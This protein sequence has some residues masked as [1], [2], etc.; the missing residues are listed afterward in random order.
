MEKI[1]RTL[2]FSVVVLLPFAQVG[3]SVSGVPIY[4]PEFP[5]GIAVVLYGVSL[6]R[7]KGSFRLTSL[8]LEWFGAG[9]FFLGAV[10]SSIS[11]GMNIQELG[12]IK[13]WFL[14][15]MVFGL[16]VS[17]VFRE[18]R[19]RERMLSFWFAVTVC[20][21]GISV[22]PLP[23]IHWTYD[24]RLTSF[25]TSPNHLAFFFE[26]G[27]LIGTYV[28]LKSVKKRMVRQGMFFF[29]ET[30][31]IFFALFETKSEGGLLSVLFGL[32]TLLS[33]AFLSKKQIIRCAAWVSVAIV[34][35]IG[36]CFYAGIPE[37]LGTGEIRNSLASRV[38]IWNAS[39]RML[40]MHPLSGIGLRTF[41]RE[42]LALQPEFPPY[43][44]WAVP[45]PHN[46]VL[47]IWLQ[48]GIVGLFGGILLIGSAL[49]LLWRKIGNPGIASG[50]NI[51]FIALLVT[52]LLHGSVDT[53]FFRNDLSLQLFLLLGLIFASKMMKDMEKKS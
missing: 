47:A 10:Y 19:A 12:S 44:E 21:A 13:S 26:P 48:T 8:R 7:G 32:I 6:Y 39:I 41:E 5:I 22:L 42:Y 46:L 33:F 2:L 15:P 36:V 38:M 17:Q 14:F 35:L 52:V 24:G 49:R 31:L 18:Q 51:L 11:A 27:V 25:F 45:H 53:P 30:A 29:I 40:Q 34:F 43:L 1:I 16:L 20:I 3:V 50:E 23:F 9:L 4:L 37:R 28:S